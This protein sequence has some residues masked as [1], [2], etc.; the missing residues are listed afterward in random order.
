MLLQQIFAGALLT[1]LTLA[2]HGLCTAAIINGLTGLH[3]RHWAV[4][5]VM[6][7]VTLVGTVALVMLGASLLEASLWSLAYLFTG[8]IE[9]AEPALYFSIVTFTTLGYGDVTLDEGSRLLSGLQAACGIIVFGWS[10]ALVI[11]VL[12]RLLIL[13]GK[14]RD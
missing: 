2:I 9:N 3:A 6:G 8:A 14:V 4:R 11:A 5:S 12:Q 13:S 7:A 1:A 10:T